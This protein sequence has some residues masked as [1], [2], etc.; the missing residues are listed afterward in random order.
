MTNTG[1]KGKEQPYDD[2]YR[3]G[4]SQG[5]SLVHHF[6]FSDLKLKLIKIYEN[7][8]LTPTRQLSSRP[9]AV[10]DCPM[11]NVHMSIYD[12]WPLQ[13][14]ACLPIL[15]SVFTPKIHLNRDNKRNSLFRRLE[16]RFQENNEDHLLPNIR[17]KSR[18]TYTRILKWTVN[19]IPTLCSSCLQV[20]AVDQM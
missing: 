7:D 6:S 18:V 2:L 14:Q 4:N 3:K 1:D 10:W 13:S 15:S 12:T 9:S 16:W 20:A 19:T 17:D 8:Y 5:P 11:D